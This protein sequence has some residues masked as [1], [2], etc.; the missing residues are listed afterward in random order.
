[1]CTDFLIEGSRSDLVDQV[2]LGQCCSNVGEPALLFGENS[3]KSDFSSVRVNLLLCVAFFCHNDM[4][5][6]KQTLYPYGY[7]LSFTIFIAWL[8]VF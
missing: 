6:L 5:F 7:F 3:N 1:M 8:V 2:Q 4:N